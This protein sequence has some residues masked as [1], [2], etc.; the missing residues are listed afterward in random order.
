MGVDRLD[1]LTDLESPSDVPSKASTVKPVVPSVQS[2]P[3]EDLDSLTRRF[4]ALKKR[5]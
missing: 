3:V 5:S 1:L 2:A 4:E